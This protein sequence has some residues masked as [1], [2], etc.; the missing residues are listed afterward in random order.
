MIIAII[1]G[2]CAAIS[3]YMI[4]FGIRHHHP[5]SYKGASFMLCGIVI[6]A[7]LLLITL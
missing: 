7:I 2:I 6:Y 5:E 4:R 1:L 3:I